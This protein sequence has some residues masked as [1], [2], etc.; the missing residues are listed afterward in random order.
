LYLSRAVN[1]DMDKHSL[2]AISK[3]YK[4]DYTDEIA[5]RADFDAEVLNKV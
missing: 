1:K 3:K 2:G 5:H 4:F